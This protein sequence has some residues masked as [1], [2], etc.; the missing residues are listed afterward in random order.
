MTTIADILQ[1]YGKE[2]LEKYDDKIVPSHRKAIIDLTQCRTEQLGGQVWVCESCNK[3][4]YSYHSCKNR[5]CPKCQN[6]LVD[7]W[8][9][10]QINRLLPAEYF[11]VTFTLPEELRDVARSHQ[12]TVYNIFFRTSAQ[13]LQT[14]ADDP[15][16][17]GGMV[18][19]L[20]VLQTWT[21]KLNY[22]PHIHYL[23]P[24]GGLAPNGKKWRRVKNNFL[25]PREPLAIILRAKF[26]DALKKVKLLNQI[27]KNV[28]QKN[29]GIDIRSVGN[30][31]TAV[32]YLAPY[33]CRGPISNRNILNQKNGSVT[34][35]FKDPNTGQYNTRTLP[36]FEFLR[37]FLQH[38]LPKRFIKVRYYGLF[39]SKRKVLLQFVKELLGKMLLTKKKIKK[40]FQFK[41]PSCGALMLLV[42]EFH[43]RR[44]PPFSFKTIIPGV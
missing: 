32:K 18:G 15:K 1:A 41:C 21:R 30:G 28:W 22:H 38:V 24:G 25:V 23:I 19:M 34:F 13:A 36:A 31:E 27:P 10:D 12:K 2:Y 4:H 9:G 44:A 8:L 43:R 16:Y 42:D 20:G 5:H 7:H 14:L 35:R 33:V 29:W 40:W 6:D 39:A 37:R 26:R 11:M 17:I 3:T